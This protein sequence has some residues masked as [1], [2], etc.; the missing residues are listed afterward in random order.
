MTGAQ[1]A[2]GPE[3]NPE[4]VMLS[5]ARAPFVALVMALFCVKASA[6][7]SLSV[8]N[9]LVTGSMTTISYSDPGKAGQTVTVEIDN[10]HPTNPVTQKVTIQLDAQ[11][12][13]SRAW[14]VPSWEVVNFN[15][16]GCS[17]ETRFVH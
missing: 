17:E 11:G 2:R 5:F 9:N 12:N 15:A 7:A 13:G 6:E 14:L 4:S 8:A 1:Q 16:A 10:G 3:P